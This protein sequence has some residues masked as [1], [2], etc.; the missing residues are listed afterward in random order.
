MAL[1]I[2]A[3]LALVTPAPALGATTFVVNRIGDAPDLSL[4]NAACDVSANAGHQCT[5]RAAIQEANDTAGVD[6]ISFN[7]TSASK[8]IT[9]ATPL[10]AITDQVTINGYSQSGA[11]PNTKA[12]NSNAVLVV[13]LDGVNAG[14]AANGLRVDSSGT[15]I[16]GI[17]IMRFGE[18]GVRIAGSGNVVAG[19]FIGTDR[20]GT[21]KRPN[22][23]GVAVFGAAIRRSSQ[24]TGW[25]SRGP[26]G[27]HRF[28]AYAAGRSIR[29]ASRSTTA[30]VVCQAVAASR[31]TRTRI[32]FEP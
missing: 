31:A 20:P 12:A 5:L 28:G 8:T 17:V 10:P 9:P 18:A 29:V 16:R 7:I 26:R 2:A 3:G 30:R 4:A 19:N 6:V 24:P 23:T 11:T 21:T 22:G 13:V 27:T 14:A 1:L 25:S 15:S 32:W